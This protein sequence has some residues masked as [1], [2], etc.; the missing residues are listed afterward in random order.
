MGL[1]G[2]LALSRRV[3]LAVLAH[4]RHNHTRY[5]QLLRET[6]YQNARRAVEPVC[7]D[8]LVKWRGDEETGRDQMDEILREVVVISDSEDGDS[9]EDSSDEHD[10]HDDHEPQSAGD[11]PNFMERTAA[12][13]SEPPALPRTNPHS[14]DA[15][16]QA[17]LA[18]GSSAP[19]RPTKSSR[20][21]QKARKNSKKV[22]K[23]LKRRQ[24]WTDAQNRVREDQSQIT[25]PAP[26]VIMDRSVSHG[27]SSALY[28]DGTTTAYGWNDYTNIPRCD[29]GLERRPM[30]VKTTTAP[31]F[32]GSEFLHH[33][34]H[35][36]GTAPSP[37]ITGF[38]SSAR[39]ERPKFSAMGPQVIQGPV[40]PTGHRY[41]DLLVPSIEP[42]SP[43]S[44]GS[45]EPIFVRSVPARHAVPG[46]PAFDYRAE[47][48]ARLASPPLLS[49]MRDEAAGQHR[50]VT[51]GQGRLSP[52]REMLSAYRPQP[53]FGPRAD[54]PVGAGGR[55]DGDRLA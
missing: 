51:S 27:S 1:N 18:T 12:D 3:Q 32:S 38:V 49:A 6:T 10:E 40:S 48:V 31:G 55:S 33:N 50:R 22:T 52:G 29:P 21:R 34:M 5:D 17:G 53:P 46:V 44:N 11:H 7:L 24:V 28:P 43:T 4:I 25:A 19:G 26:P 14:A 41:R 13:K 8:F 30:E 20:K 16:V 54:L 23:S 47:Q 42:P 15:R 39:A 9:D 37:S 45:N 35:F 36:S 2:N